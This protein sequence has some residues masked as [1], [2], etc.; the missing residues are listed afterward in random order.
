MSR[1]GP[2]NRRSEAAEHSNPVLHHLPPTRVK[3]VA[4]T[5]QMSL[6]TPGG[7]RTRRRIG[8]PGAASATP[9]YRAGAVGPVHPSSSSQAL[10]GSGS[11]S[12]LLPGGGGQG[13]SAMMMAADLSEEQRQEIREAFELFDT[14]KDGAIDYHELKVAMRALGFDLKK[15]EVLSIL[16]KADQ[17]GQGVMRWEDFNRISELSCPSGM[18]SQP[19]GEARSS[20]SHRPRYSVRTGVAERSDGGDQTGVPAL[21]RRQHGQD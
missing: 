20:P 15:D 14:D 6:A 11:G 17:S 10:N 8:T 9:N 2:S 5:A 21:R 3:F 19:S 16:R 18:S 13:S 7:A 4:L 12:H 1:G